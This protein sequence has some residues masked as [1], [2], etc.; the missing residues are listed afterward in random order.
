MIQKSIDPAHT[1]Q[2][3][4]YLEAVYKKLYPPAKN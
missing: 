3:R 1:G 4:R 2:L